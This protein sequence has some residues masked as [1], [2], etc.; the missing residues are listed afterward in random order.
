MNPTSSIAL[1]ALVIALVACQSSH[2]ASVEPTNQNAPLVLTVETGKV[3]RQ[4]ADEVLG[5]NVNYLRDADANRSGGRTLRAALQTLGVRWLRYPGGEKS[6]F[7]QW[8]APPYTAPSPRV[9]G[10]YRSI[11]GA[12]MDFDQFIAT[13]RAVGA[14]PYVVVGY[15]SEKRTG[16]K[17]S[18]WLQDAVALVRYANVTKRYGVR[19]W[20][21][22]NENWNHN[23]FRPGEIA[24]VTAAFSKAMKA[25]DPDIRIGSSGSDMKWWQGLLPTLSP[26]IDFLA[27]SLYNTDRWKN[28]DHWLKNPDANLTGPAQV[29]LD[30]IQRYAQPKDRKRLKLVVAETNSVNWSKRGWKSTNSLGHSLVTFDTFGRLLHEPR[31]MAA[32]LWGTRW[33]KDSESNTSAFYALGSQNQVLPTG[34]A[35]AMWGQFLKSEMVRVT[36]GDRF[37]TAFASRSGRGDRLTVWIL[38]RA[39]TP[40]TAI[41]IQLNASR[42]FASAQCFRWSGDGPD[43][44]SPKWES[45]GK[46]DVTKNRISLLAIPATSVSVLEFQL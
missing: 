18:E 5:I 8:A 29:A 45:L 9:L 4:G 27:I 7:V 15:D 33:I 32:L 2:G 1:S 22:G 14:E 19:Y 3:I 24:R 31:V 28:Y 23:T 43:D 26:H 41:T 17:E 10:A 36:G 6:D 25:V 40:R 21:I 34:R 12:R 35:L 11:K 44:L 39:R 16:R 37:V 42:K 20:E 13:A 38:N 30:A 46:I